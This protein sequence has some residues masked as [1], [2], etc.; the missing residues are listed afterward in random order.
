MIFI[1]CS[2]CVKMFLTHYLQLCSL[3]V[4]TF[5]WLCLSAIK[6]IVCSIH[7]CYDVDLVHVYIVC[8]LHSLVLQL[9]IC[10]P[11][12]EG[13]RF[14]DGQLIEVLST[15][16]FLLSSLWL[17]SCSERPWFSIQSEF[18]LYAMVA[19]SFSTS[20]T[21]NRTCLF[22][23][24]SS[25][26]LCCNLLIFHLILMWLMQRRQPV[27]WGQS[28]GPFISC[29]QHIQHRRA[30]WAYKVNLLLGFDHVLYYEI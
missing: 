8:L 15:P 30:D 11:I 20:A 27:Q 26:F 14:L 7:H 22:H 4:L 19:L 2:K 29:K 16:Y 5:N 10:R 17:L 18:F 21:R 6:D 25:S 24:E 3:K 28:I 12:L 1:I 9:H 13:S 23:V